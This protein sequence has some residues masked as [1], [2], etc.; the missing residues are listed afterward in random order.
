MRCHDY[1]ALVTTVS[2]H[3]TLYSSMQVLYLCVII[4]DI[5]V[6]QASYVYIF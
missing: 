6:I 4:S 2:I 3:G 1:I 5:Q